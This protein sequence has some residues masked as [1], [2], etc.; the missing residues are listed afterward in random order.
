MRHSFSKERLAQLFMVGFSGTGIEEELRTLIEKHH[1]TSFILFRENLHDGSALRSMIEEAGALALSLQLSPTLFAAD[2]EGGLISP[3]G[4]VVGRLPSPM[5][6]AAGGSADLA[7]RAVAMVGEEIKG[8]GVDLVLAPVLDVNCEPSNPVI[9]TRSFGD[10][11]NAV[12]RMGAAVIDGLHSAGL[13]CCV[14]HFP[15]HGSTLRDSHKA[16]PVVYSS[17]VELS[18]RDMVPFRRVFEHGVDAV[19]TAHVAYPDVDDGAVRPSTVSRRIQTEL[20]RSEMGF[21]GALLSDSME[22]MGV[23]ESMPPEQACVEALKA[24]VDLF[25][26]VDP[27]LALR[28]LDKVD[29][30]LSSGDLEPETMDL[31]IARIAQLR[32][33]SSRVGRHEGSGSSDGAEVVDRIISLTKVL[34]ECYQTSLTLLDC[35]AS[36]LKERLRAIERGLLIVPEGLPGYDV[37][38]LD[39]IEGGLRDLRVADRWRVLP[40]PFDPAHEDVHRVISHVDSSDGTL[41][42]TLSRGP[43]PEG[44]RRLATALAGT[45]VLSAGAALLDPYGLAR[46]FP[47][48]LPRVATYGFWPDCLRALMKLLFG[49]ASATGALPIDI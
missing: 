24:G 46:L 7:R 31:A 19:M 11:P 15:G 5:A 4:E 14:K 17:A 3:L 49:Q 41:F 44:Q 13:S 6:L 10:D 42:C 12:G 2:E 9:G 25:I 45:G 43:E 34:G 38:D 29:E 16:L 26:C 40:Y 23:A 21:G 36:G 20:L 39:L 22:M 32:N 33:R 18:E 28:C 37:L 27:D 48:G 8:L 1:F 35:E 47:A 30:H